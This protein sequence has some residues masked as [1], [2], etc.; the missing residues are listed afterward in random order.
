MLA[1]KR[2]FV[3]V[4]ILDFLQKVESSR[5]FAISIEFCV[6]FDNF[7]RSF[8]FFLDNVKVFLKFRNSGEFLQH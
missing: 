8:G 6:D 4:A 1:S 2:F 7:G 5:F 3:A